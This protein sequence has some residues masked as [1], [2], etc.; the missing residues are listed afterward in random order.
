MIDHDEMIA[1]HAIYGKAPHQAGT[2]A[3][4]AAVRIAKGGSRSR[5]VPSAEPWD[6]AALLLVQLYAGWWFQTF[7]IFHNIWDNPFHR[8]L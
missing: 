8:L 7:F 1:L 6:P 4:R 5:Q 2:A 3:L